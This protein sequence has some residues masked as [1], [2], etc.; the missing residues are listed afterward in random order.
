[1]ATLY[2]LTGQF[3]EL[4]ELLDQGEY[5]EDLIRDTLE[6]VEFDLEEK[7]EGYAKI[8]RNYESDIEGMKNEEKRIR[9]RRKALENNVRRLKDNLQAAMVQTGKTKFKKGIFSFA[10]QKNGGKLPVIIDAEE[11]P[12]E[13]VITIEKPDMDALAEYIKKNP[14]NELAHFGE[15]GESLRIR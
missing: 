9:E 14:E 2:E 12:K 6:G 8:I 7:A 15:R 1:M 4:S 10:I 11:L 3:L 13:F 5:D